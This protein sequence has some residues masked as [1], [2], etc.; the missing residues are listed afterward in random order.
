[1]IFEFND[2]SRNVL[3][4]VVFS[5]ILAVLLYQWSANLLISQL[6]A[7]VLIR[8]DIDLTYWLLHW[9][10]IVELISQNYW[11]GIV[12]NLFL[13]GSTLSAI[14]WPRKR[15]F[16]ILATIFF[17]T[18][19]I[20]LN[21][22]MNWHYHNIITLIFLLLPFCTRTIKQFSL[23]FAGARYALLY[24]YASAAI[25]KLSRGSVFNPGQMNW[26]IEHNYIDRMA[27]KN[28]SPSFFEQIMISLLDHPTLMY[29]LLIMGV[30]MEAAFLIGFF[31]R[32]FDWALIIIGIT[33][34]IFTTILVD[35]S[36][37]QLWIVFITLIPFQKW[38]ISNKFGIQRIFS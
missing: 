17:M 30:T 28:F 4:R 21:S 1:M 29:G 5:W 25:W 33:F 10:G 9:T 15:I 3:T 14:I 31:T 18:Y 24:V 22:F 37:I 23:W 13:F 2:K 19:V 7:P 26:L 34:H 20:S 32:K 35:V 36:F 38:L 6:E 8:T 12:F 11:A 16:T 27:E